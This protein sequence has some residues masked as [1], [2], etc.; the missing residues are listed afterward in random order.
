M[1]VGKCSF[2]SL[3]EIPSGFRQDIVQGF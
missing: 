3:Y 1:K 2:N